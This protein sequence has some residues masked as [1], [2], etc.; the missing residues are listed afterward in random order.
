MGL[1]SSDLPGGDR[2]ANMIRAIEYVD[3]A[4]Q[5][6]QSMDEDSFV[7]RVNGDLKEPKMH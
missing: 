7:Q 4:L 3:A 6:F 2:V 1:T 5:L